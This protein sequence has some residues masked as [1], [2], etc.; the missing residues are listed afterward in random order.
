MSEVHRVASEC[1]A[2]DRE[3]SAGRGN[4]RVGRDE[5]WLRRSV[6]LGVGGASPNSPKPARTIIPVMR[7]R[8]IWMG[9]VQEAEW[10]SSER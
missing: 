5:C 8:L 9:I 6:G 4:R 10:L 3:V 7:T 2:G 1:G